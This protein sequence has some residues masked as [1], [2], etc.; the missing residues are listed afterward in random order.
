MSIKSLDQERAAYA[1]KCVT[2]QTAN[3]DYRK[4]AKSLPALIMA[5]G[6]M[7]T[8]A[9]LKSK[10]KQGHHLLL[11]AHI[12]DW[13]MT[14]KKPALPESGDQFKSGFSKIMDGLLKMKPEDYRRATEESLAILRWIRQLADAAIG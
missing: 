12:C 2:V 13:A 1:W 10:E 14:E 7:Q 8:F 9:F 5:N 4:L 3:S 11:G 6:L